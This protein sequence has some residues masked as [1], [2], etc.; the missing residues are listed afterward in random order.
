[1][2]KNN[3]LGCSAGI[4]AVYSPGS[5]D[6]P[7]VNISV[8]NDANSD[9]GQVD[10]QNGFIV[11]GYRAEFSRPLSFTR[12][13]NMPG[14]VAVLGFG[15][16]TLELTGLVGEASAFKALT[17]AS[18]EQCQFLYITINSGSGTQ[19]CHY[20][21]GVATETKAISTGTKIICTGGVVERV[22]LGMQS[23]DNGI[24]MQSGSVVMRITG[25]RIEGADI[26]NTTGHRDNTKP[27]GGE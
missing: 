13:L 21:D 10:T 25:M 24:I 23:Q 11:Q 18:P 12:A 14:Q 3:I 2:N 7:L 9:G 1:M 26:K 17:N 19:V 4:S 16:G 8:S 15:S 6:T 22:Q 5:G 20:K 27:N